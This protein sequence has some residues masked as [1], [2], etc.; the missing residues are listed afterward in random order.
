MTSSVR[1]VVRGIATRFG[2]LLAALFVFPFP[3]GYLPGTKWFG[4]LADVPMD[5]MTQWVGET[6]FG[7]RV[8]PLATGSG[9]KTYDYLG[10]L[11]TVMLAVL[12]TIVWSVLDRRRTA[13]PWLVAALR[14]AL[15]YWMARAMLSYGLLKVLKLQFPD[16]H[17]ARLA[18]PL[19]EMKPMLLLW[20]FMG[21]STSYS[22]FAGLAETL[23]G[24]LLLWRRTATLG[25]VLVAAV[26]TNVVMLNFCYDVPVKLYSM[27]LLIAAIVIA[28]PGARRMLIAALGGAVADIQP[29]TRWAPRWERARR[30]AKLVVVTGIVYALCARIYNIPNINS[31]RHE[32]YGAWTVDRFVVDGLERPPLATDPVR[33][34]MVAANPTRLVIHP[35]TGPRELMKLV[36]DATHHTLAV[37]PEDSKNAADNEIWSYTRTAPDHLEIVAV[38]LGMHLQLSLHLQP[39]AP[40][41][42]RGFHWINE[43][44][45]SESVF[46][47]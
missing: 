38:H 9:D 31:H 35:M 27:Q 1:G 11:T 45:A 46:N 7:L 20:S 21:A 39:E 16:L 5:R 10:V 4:E 14:I 42:A 29:R 19:G 3:L 13:Y 30:I 37:V 22:V 18:Q 25:A 43:E 47:R 34:R 36:V 40:L 24:A 17:L 41:L 8:L 26:M 33:W 32:L 6:M 12:G 44:P 2:I 28:L 23:G 15:R